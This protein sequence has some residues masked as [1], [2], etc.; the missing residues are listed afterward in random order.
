MMLSTVQESRWKGDPNH[1]ILEDEHE[2]TM[3]S[4]RNMALKLV[5]SLID[6]YGD[7]A[8]QA[9]VT[10]ADRFIHGGSK[11]EMRDLARKFIKQLN[12][13]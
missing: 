6:N 5:S 8:T 2:E 10:V 4:I 7:I 12:I 9:V 1:F 13:D 3:Y 11:D